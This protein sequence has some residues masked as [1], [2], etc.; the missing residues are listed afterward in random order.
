MTSRS[1]LNIFG[2]RIKNRDGEWG[3]MRGETMTERERD[4]WTSRHRK[5]QQEFTASK[6]ERNREKS[7]RVPKNGYILL[8]QT[9]PVFNRPSHL[10]PPIPISL[11][12][13]SFSDVFVSP[14]TDGSCW[15][16]LTDWSACDSI[17][18]RGFSSRESLRGPG[19]GGK[20]SMLSRSLS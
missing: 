2:L 7:R 13:A 18:G 6:R 17:I 5:E 4:K 11:Q 9:C 19:S 14:G 20:R 8:G 16:L 3:S 12:K 15:I 10:F 1:L